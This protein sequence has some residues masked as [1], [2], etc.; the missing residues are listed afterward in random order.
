MGNKLHI[1]LKIQSDN[2]Q[3][4]YIVLVVSRRYSDFEALYNALLKIVAQNML[5]IPKLPPKT[6]YRSESVIRQRMQDLEE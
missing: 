2:Y 6:L 5:I 4:A 1:Y 3:G